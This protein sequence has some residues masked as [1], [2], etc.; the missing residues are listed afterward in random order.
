MIL[1]VFR[2]KT[3]SVSRIAA[4]ASAQLMLTPAEL[5]V[6]DTARSLTDI[7]IDR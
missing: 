1:A 2:S 6:R 5:E 4:Y 3:R 7:Q